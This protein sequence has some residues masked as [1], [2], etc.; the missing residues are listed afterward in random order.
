MYFLLKLVHLNLNNLSLLAGR[1]DDRRDRKRIRITR[2]SHTAPY[3]S[4]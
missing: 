4:R 1:S 3:R 2:E